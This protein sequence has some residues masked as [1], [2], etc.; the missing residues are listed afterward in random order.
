LG[1]SVGMLIGSTVCSGL[2]LIAGCV[3]KF[4]RGMDPNRFR[5]FVSVACGS[6]SPATTRMAL[7]GAYHLS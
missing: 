5:I 3:P 6:R 7:F 2:G 1:L 4:L